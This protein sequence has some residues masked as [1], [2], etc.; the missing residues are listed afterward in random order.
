MKTKNTLSLSCLIAAPLF[1]TGCVDGSLARRD[2]GSYPVVK[3]DS[4]AVRVKEIL[5][6][7]PKL[8]PGEAYEKAN[9]ETAR[10]DAAAEAAYFKKKKQKEERD[11]FLKD[12]ADSGK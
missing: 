10:D 6:S 1:V 7:N 3:S 9:A 8:T 5:L 11:E 12:L 4:S 2:D